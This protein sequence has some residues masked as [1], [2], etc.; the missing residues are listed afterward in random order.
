MYVSQRIKQLF[1]QANKKYDDYELYPDATPSS[2]V[3]LEVE[4][5]N[6]AHKLAGDGISYKYLRAR[7]FFSRDISTWLSIHGEALMYDICKIMLEDGGEHFFGLWI[8]WLVKPIPQSGVD[9]TLIRFQP[10]LRECC[11]LYKIPLVPMSH[12]IKDGSLTF[13]FQ[14]FERISNIVAIKKIIAESIQGEEYQ[15]YLIRIPTDYVQVLGLANGKATKCY[16]NASRIAEGKGPELE[17][18][19]GAKG[20]KRK[21][22]IPQKLNTQIPLSAFH[23]E[24][25]LSDNDYL[26]EPETSDL[27]S[28]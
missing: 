23:C 28:D 13:L 4:V 16:S 21:S 2:L 22:F 7:W 10:F 1:V 19:P 6:P 25:R 24:E 12:M 15:K 3:P 14:E 11:A 9:D 17:D 18:M 20:S 26:S 27:D 8:Y 5:D